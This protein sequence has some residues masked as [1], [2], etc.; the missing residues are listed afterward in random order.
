MASATSIP[1]LLKLIADASQ[2][3]L[4]LY[5]D[6]HQQ[7]KNLQANIQTNQARQAGF[8]FGSSVGGAAAG[9]LPQSMAPL[10][11][12]AGSLASS[13]FKAMNAVSSARQAAAAASAAGGSVGGMTAL[14]ATPVLGEGIAAAGLAII[15]LKMALVDLPSAIYGWT[16]SLLE[17][18][19]AVAKYSPELSAIF[20]GMEAKS[21]VRDQSFGRATYKSTGE[22][23]DSSMAFQDAMMP[24]KAVLTNIENRIGGALLD[25][26]SNIVEGIADLMGLAQDYAQPASFDVMAKQAADLERE[27]LAGRRRDP[28]EQPFARR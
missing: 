12:G 8:N 14:L 25:A 21:I 7:A 6:Q 18:Q 16:Q 5:K 15:G 20:L 3:Q 1:D 10:A 2:A 26:L 4:Q 19:K 13:G 9:L 22:L 24:L 11:Q 28:R 27:H 17:S 23:A